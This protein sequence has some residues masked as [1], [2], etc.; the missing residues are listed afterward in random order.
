MFCLFL[1]SFTFKTAL[2][3]DL[4]LIFPLLL[5]FFLGLSFGLSLEIFWRSEVFFNERM[6]NPAGFCET[7]WLFAA[8]KERKTSIFSSMSEAECLAAKARSIM[9][10]NNVAQ[11]SS[12][13]WEPD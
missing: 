5:G 8:T 9:K 1:G 12:S 4:A 6:R 7:F 2:V 11:T 13:G 3:A 10:R